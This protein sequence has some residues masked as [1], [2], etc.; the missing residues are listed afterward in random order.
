MAL[1]IELILRASSSR[2]SIEQFSSLNAMISVQMADSVDS[3]EMLPPN[4]AGQNAI[5]DY[6]LALETKLGGLEN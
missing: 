4:A 6:I 5:H 2:L 1:I 3:H